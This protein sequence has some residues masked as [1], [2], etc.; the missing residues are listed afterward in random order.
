[1]SNDFTHVVQELCPGFLGAAVL[2]EQA[3][4]AWEGLDAA[5]RVVVEEEVRQMTGSGAARFY[6]LIALLGV[7]GL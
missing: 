6:R 5:A 1:M 4:V 7:T 2:R 3:A